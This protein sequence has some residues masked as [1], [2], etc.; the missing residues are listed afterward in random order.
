VDI[1]GLFA[2]SCIGMNRYFLAI[3]FVI[4][5]FLLAPTPVLCETILAK[6]G[7]HVITLEKLQ[8]TLNSTPYGMPKTKNIDPGSKAIM[9]QMLG[10]MI[11]AELLYDEAV[12]L[13]IQN[14][15]DFK[16]ETKKF[17]K[18]L[19]A[20]L[21]RE[22]LYE[23]STLKDEGVIKKFAVE[24]SVSE[25]SAKAILQGEKRKTALADESSKL[26]DLYQVRYS[27]KIAKGNPELFADNEVLVSSNAFNIPYGDIK[28]AV[29]NLEGKNG[30]LDILA[31]TVE[32]ELFAKRAEEIGLYKDKKFLDQIGSYKKNLAI[33]I[34]RDQL[35]K[36]YLPSAQEIEEFIRNND[37][38]HYKSQRATALMI[39][40]KT[41]QEAM[42]IR[43]LAMNGENFFELAIANSIAPDAKINAGRI[44]SVVIGEHP[45]NAIEKALLGLK[46]GEITKPIKGAKGFSIFKLIDIQPRELQNGAE[47][48]EKAIN[49]LVG[50]KMNNHLDSLHTKAHVETYPIPGLLPEETI[51]SQ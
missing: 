10:E 14:S 23:S 18:M 5:F 48:R 22:K 9:V 3:T 16:L 19:L 42:K 31:Q 13:N 45:Y 46:P 49:M 37:Y 40:T 38:I 27:Q 8:M 6:V 28:Q 35:I 2:L 33:S 30:L 20:D 44:N 12:A 36:K 32:V 21:Y 17:Q 47:I 25:E 7:S 1:T 11:N 24:K 50:V 29:K 4:T 41:E 34:H 26:F 39:V 51:K 43:G 15:E